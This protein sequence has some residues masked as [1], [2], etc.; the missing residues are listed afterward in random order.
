MYVHNRNANAQ[1]LVACKLMELQ[2]KSLFEI[3]WLLLLL[4]DLE[5]PW[6][7]LR[8]SSTTVLLV[9]VT[10]VLVDS[11]TVV[12]QLCVA[13]M[14]PFTSRCKQGKGQR[15]KL[16]STVRLKFPP[17]WWIFWASGNSYW[18]SHWIPYCACAFFLS[19]VCN[20][21]FAEFSAFFFCQLCLLRN[22]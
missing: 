16:W 1:S 3:T 22:C 20:F 9:N 17:P 19:A 18:I 2:G 11:T 7:R 6:S 21:A 5:F 4:H 14:L 12:Q 15:Q 10:L 13:L 8:N